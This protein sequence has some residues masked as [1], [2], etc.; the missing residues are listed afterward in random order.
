MCK[1]CI[2]ESGYSLRRELHEEQALLYEN[3]PVFSFIKPSQSYPNNS[4]QE[5]G[6]RVNYQVVHYAHDH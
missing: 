4:R 1:N 6:K 3:W 5:T 2:G